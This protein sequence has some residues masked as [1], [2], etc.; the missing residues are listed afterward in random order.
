MGYNSDMKKRKYTKKDHM[1]RILKRLREGPASGMDLRSYDPGSKPLSRSTFKGYID[2]LRDMGYEIDQHGKGPYSL[3]EE[4]EKYEQFD[5]NTASEWMIMHILDSA[6]QGLTYR[7]L[8]RRYIELSSEGIDEERTCDAVKHY[9]Y[10]HLFSDGTFRKA[11]VSLK[12]S[13]IIRVLRR[14]G[15]NTAPVYELADRNHLP[16]EISDNEQV[17]FFQECADTASISLL[18][19][20]LTSLFQKMEAILLDEDEKYD[21]STNIIAFGK[22]N[23]IEGPLIAKLNELSHIPFRQHQITISYGKGRKI[24]HASA[25]YILYNA[26]TNMIYILY[27]KKKKSHLIRL[28]Q[29]NEIT[30]EPDRENCIYHSSH[31]RKMIDKMWTVSDE[32]ETFVHVIFENTPFIL[33]K[34]EAAASQRT[35]AQIEFENDVI[36]YRDTVIGLNEFAR[37]LRG[38]GSSAIVLEPEKL[39]RKMKISAEETLKNY[40]EVLS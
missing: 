8:K 9:S 28:D 25:A 10:N 16:L 4:P 20:N 14:A 26:E 34:L 12:E 11:I 38:F 22:K 27:E 21:T 39:A 40:E 5:K 7:E 1:E 13:G 19:E 17:D 3:Q 37:F 31:Y 15:T 36:H 32:P 30:D 29:I 23:N 33:D 18:E 35:A 24:T 6:H 2:C